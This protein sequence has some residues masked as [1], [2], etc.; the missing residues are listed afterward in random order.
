MASGFSYQL[1]EVLSM[2]SSSS[3]PTA[4]SSPRLFMVSAL[5]GSIGAFLS[6]QHLRMDGKIPGLASN[7]T[8]ASIFL[9]C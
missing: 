1:S 6:V 8:P 5:E 9:W 4:R 2:S 7:G 3:S